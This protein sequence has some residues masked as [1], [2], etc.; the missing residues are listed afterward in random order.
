MP[1]AN[2]QTTTL[3]NKNGSPI[4]SL[5]N[6]TN[7][8]METGVYPD[9]I[10]PG[11]EPH[12]PFPFSPYVGELPIPNTIRP[13]QQGKL[14]L[15]MLPAQVR[16]HPELPAT[17]RIW[18]Y[19]ISPNPDGI[20]VP[21][22][23]TIE[24]KENQKLK[25]SFINALI[26]DGQHAK[27]PVVAVHD[28]PKYVRII[29]SGDVHAPENL[30]GFSC[31]N[32]DHSVSAL[33]PWTVVHLHGGRT[34]ANSDGWP[35]NAIYPRQTQHDTYENHQP[36][37]MLWYHDHG[38][39]ITRLNVHAGLAGLYFIR[40]PQEKCLGL[41][42]RP[43][44]E[45]PLVIQDR[46]LTCEG[47]HEGI[48][49]Y[50]LLH[51]TGTAGGKPIC[52][53]DDGTDGSVDQAPMEF[54]GPLTMVNGCIWPKHGVKASVYRL[55]ILNGSNA[56]TY[57]LW[58]TDTEGNKL[59]VPMQMLGSDG[60]L[61]EKPV[62]LNAADR[63]GAGCI[64]LASAERVDILVD[65]SMFSNQSIELRNSAG[66]PFNGADANLSDPL[67]DFLPYPQ[68]MRFDV[69]LPHR[70]HQFLPEN[71]LLLPSAKPWSLE[72]VMVKQRVQRLMALVE[73]DKGVLQLMEC[74]QQ[75]D[76]GN[77]PVIW[78][79]TGGLPPANTLALRQ[80]GENA[81]YLYCLLPGM[82]SDPVRYLAAD[83]D[84]EIWKVINLTG[85]THPVHVHLIQFKLLT[86]DQYS[87]ID[88][89]T[90]AGYEIHFNT[91]ASDIILDDAE[92]GWKDT[93]RVNPS[94]LVIFA[95]P[96]RDYASNDTGVDDGKAIGITGRY[97]YHCHILEHEDH[98]MM[99]PYVVMPP[100][101]IAHMMHMHD[102]NTLE[103]DCIGEDPAPMENM[104]E[105]SGWYMLPE[106]PPCKD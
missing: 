16:L 49:A 96:F 77:N 72:E 7:R 13:N 53:G 27:H 36:G 57:R 47:D 71:T 43:P 59:T 34:E 63:P 25:V 17:T 50:Q 93:I 84:I 35:E 38:M 89:D 28:L 62:D 92:R 83:G 60:G 15:Y 32:H 2:D 14:K 73:D 56:R 24:V 90:G 97:V 42:C 87:D 20:K 86:R 44:F 66:A 45:I 88:H 29:S 1:L 41:P 70:K 102:Q 30:L 64:T 82:F 11:P 101:V 19:H 21:L 22:G 94:E 55:R 37:T 67:A 52:V 33:P 91:A 8:C 104:P 6:T 40:A 68:V 46:S 78:D 76:A 103:G 48:P 26:E 85:D 100:A 65:F 105:H 54:F 74:I 61:L 10:A 81:S 31:G 69:G 80:R 4:N 18:T 79:E 98:E 5:S 3:N 95:V 39:G 58:F 23:P 12:L 51:K 99:R 9:N 106:C 75:R